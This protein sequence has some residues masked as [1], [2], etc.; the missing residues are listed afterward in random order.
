[1]ELLPV[2]EPDIEGAVEIRLLPER[3]MAAAR[4]NRRLIEQA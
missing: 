2:L 3:I 1:M 4:K